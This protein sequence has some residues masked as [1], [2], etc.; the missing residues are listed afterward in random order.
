MPSS[1]PAS[2]SP[3]TYTITAADHGKRLDTWLAE[4]YQLSR[5]AA[6]TIIQQSKM[7]VGA[8]PAKPSLILQAADILTGIDPKAR[9]L[10]DRKWTPGPLPLDILFEDPH[11]LVVNKP[12]ELISH[13]GAGS[14][15]TTLIEGVMFYLGYAQSYTEMEAHEHDPPRFGLLH[16]LDKDTTGAVVI[17]KTTRAY[18]H[19]HHQLHS[20]TLQRTYVSLLDGCL[21]KATHVCE[22]YLSRSPKNRT[23]F[24]AAAVDV[25]AARYPHDIPPRYRYA[26]SE[27]Q[28]QA[29]FGHRF[30]L[31][32]VKLTTGRTHQ[33][34]VHARWLGHPV[35]GDPTY[36]DPGHRFKKKATATSY[37][38]FMHELG[39]TPIPVHRQMLHSRSLG[40]IHP[41]RDEHLEVTA[42]LPQ[43]FRDVL[44]SL[45]PY[46][47]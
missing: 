36:G 15:K 7:Q 29:T 3:W 30:D 47:V 17:A 8:K 28:H 4:H 19:L 9:V 43:D 37:Q 33:I 34:R 42:P 6:K 20:R 27:F 32:S 26:K 23:R 46:I 44:L 39:A 31:C 24:E 41:A 35:M 22:A 5:A 21:D 13:P 40:L 14:H 11:V 16:R 45:Q 2:S 25:I 12:A 18:Q 38:H 1:R 10:D